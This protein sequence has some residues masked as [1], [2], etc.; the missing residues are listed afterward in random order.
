MYYICFNQN[1]ST[2]ENTNPETEITTEELNNALLSHIVLHNDNR[3]TFEHVV[4]SLMAFAGQSAEQAEQCATIAHEKGKCSIITWHNYND[5][6]R[7]HE[8]LNRV[9]LKVTLE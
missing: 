6:K 4:T 7:P 5:L 1:I 3:N 2:V 8:I 9:G